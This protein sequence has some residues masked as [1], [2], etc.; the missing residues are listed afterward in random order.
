MVGSFGEP[1]G[2][3]VHCGILRA[4][5]K[6]GA[7]KIALCR[8]AL[9]LV[10]KRQRRRPCKYC[11]IS[12]VQSERRTDGGE[13]IHPIN[14][15]DGDHADNV[16]K[17][18]NLRP[19]GIHVPGAHLDFLRQTISLEERESTT[20]RH[21]HIAGRRHK[22]GQNKIRSWL[23]QI[24]Q[25]LKPALC[26][27]H[28]RQLTHLFNTKEHADGDRDLDHRCNEPKHRHARV[29][30]ELGR[31]EVRALHRDRVA[32]TLRGFDLLGLPIQFPG[33]WPQ[34]RR[35]AHPYDSK[36]E[37]NYSPENRSRDEGVEPRQA[38]EN[39]HEFEGVLHQACGGPVAE[40]KCLEVPVL[41]WRY[42]SD[43]I[44]ESPGVS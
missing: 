26:E 36:G 40:P 7:R 42:G 2:G 3:G 13:P 6:A 9:T 31:F 33:H 12:G 44:R 25:P 4:V 35:V 34:A 21:H 10:T 24:G 38:G 1:A 41:K 32:Y 11:Q 22:N 17:V 8:T 5:R 18:A 14:S 27:L 37:N 20:D 39:V 29:G 19:G 15:E 16:H 23:C 28:H 43:S 30:P